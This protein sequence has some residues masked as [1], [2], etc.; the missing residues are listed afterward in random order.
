MAITV[1]MAIPRGRPGVDTFICD[2]TIDVTAS[3][4]NDITTHPVDTRS[5][6]SSHAY[7]KNPVI[8]VNGV[9]TGS[10]TPQDYADNPSLMPDPDRNQIGYDL[11]RVLQALE[12]LTEL[13]R[14][15]TPFTIESAN[16]VYDNCILKSFN[17]TIDKFSGFDLIF[18]IT[19]EQVRFAETQ[20]VRITVLDEAIRDDGEDNQAGRNTKLDAETEFILDDASAASISSLVD[21]TR[22]FVRGSEN[23]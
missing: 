8:T 1:F 5:N 10:Y 16:N 7:N 2:A 17:H 15:R 6:I 13:W 9:V 18:T 14:E 4:E 22:V 23:G 20:R 11:D 12:L 21:S 3:F 19:V